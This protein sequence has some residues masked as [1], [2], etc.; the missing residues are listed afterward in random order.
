MGCELRL[1]V[2]HNEVKTKPSGLRITEFGEGGV[3]YR[4]K[5]EGKNYLP[6]L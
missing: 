4:R 6:S 1:S 3:F 5:V 2:S